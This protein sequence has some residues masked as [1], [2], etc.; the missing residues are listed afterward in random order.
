MLSMLPV[1]LYKRKLLRFYEV[2]ILLPRG[3]PGNVKVGVA[4]AIAAVERR[5]GIASC[6]ATTVAPCTLQ[7]GRWARRGFAAVLLV[8]ICRPRSAEIGEG[9]RYGQGSYEFF[10]GD[11]CALSFQPGTCRGARGT[12]HAKRKARI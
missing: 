5:A 9:V 4:I 6:I 2:F 8:V 3:V 11:D 12:P 7:S 1:I 10:E